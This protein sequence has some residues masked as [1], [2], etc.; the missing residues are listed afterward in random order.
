MNDNKKYKI[1]KKEEKNRQLEI[2]L[3]IEQNFVESFKNK[4]IKNIG[5]DVEIKGFRKGMAPEKLI[6]D[7]IGEIKI[8]EEMAFQAINEILPVLIMEEKINALTHPQINITKIAP[9]NPVAL[10]II[11]ILLPEI[12]LADY[13]KIALDTE[14][15]ENVVVEEKEIEDYINYIRK[16]RSEADN[17]K[18]KTTNSDT[19]QNKE[20]KTD[21]AEKINLP[22]FNDEFVK[23]LGNF[24]NVADFKKQ[25]RENMESQKKEHEKEKRRIAIVEKIIEKSKISLPDILVEEEMERMV[26]QFKNN[27]KQYKMEPDDY[28]KEI[29]KTENDLRNEWRGDAIKRAKMNLLL[30][31][32]AELEK[33]SADPTEVDHE[34]KHLQEHHQIDAGRARQYVQFVLNN[35]MVLKFLEDLK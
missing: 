1:I 20:E 18:N 30:P 32:I 4:S 33:I 9:N 34:V 24:E 25:L 22:E 5:K 26:E 6:I 23:S 7:Q 11:F 2:E 29:K 3:E 17:L 21:S 14:R 35:Q 10:K 19:T 13:K 12:E 8:L 31:K 16:T 27:I 28:L 15:N